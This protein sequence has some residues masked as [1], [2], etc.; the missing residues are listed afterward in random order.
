[1]TTA[2]VTIPG[3]PETDHR[4]R[5]TSR[6]TF[7]PAAYRA[8]MATVRLYAL[9]ARP[10]GWPLDARYSVSITVH[11]P[12][13]RSRDLD[14][15]AKGALDGMTGALWTDDRQIDAL[16][17]VRG[18]VRKAAPCVVVTVQRMEAA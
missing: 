4:A 14:N 9:A 15:A 1:M 13:R 8:Y 17:I 10:R 12:D 2:T 11:E 6:G 3:K 16:S 7:M 5:V 18:E